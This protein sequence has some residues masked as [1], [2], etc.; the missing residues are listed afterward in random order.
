MNE[1]FNANGGYIG[2]FEWFLDINRNQAWTTLVVRD[3][4]ENDDM[5]FNHVVKTLANTP[6][7]APVYYIIAGPEKQQVNISNDFFSFN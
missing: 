5:D 7:I 3:C 4:F 2:L 1:R 6:L